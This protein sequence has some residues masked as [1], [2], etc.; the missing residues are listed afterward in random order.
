M[1][2]RVANDEQLRTVLTEKGVTIGSGK[3]LGVH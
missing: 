3:D 2:F 1:I